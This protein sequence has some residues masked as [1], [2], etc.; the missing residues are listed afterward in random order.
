MYWIKQ[1][2]YEGCSHFDNKLDCCHLLINQMIFF[3]GG[4]FEPDVSDYIIT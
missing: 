3:I 2:D 4:I 1:I